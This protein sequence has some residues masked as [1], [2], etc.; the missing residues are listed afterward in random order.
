MKKQF[1]IIS[2]LVLFA[3]AAQAGITTYTFTS[4]QWASKVD[5]TQ[6][7][8][9]TDGWICEQAASEYNAGRTDAQG[10]LNSAGVSV[11]TGT[12][13]AGALSI[14]SFQQV[15]QVTF[16]FCLNSSRG[17]GVIYVQVGNSPWDSLVINRPA[18]SGSGIYNRDS[19]LIIPNN[20]SGKIRF[21]ITCTENA[22]NLNSITIRAQNGGSSVFTTDTYQLVTDVNQLQDSDQVIFGVADGVSNRIMGYFD[23]SVSQNNIHSIVGRYSADRTQVEPND[24]AI[25][26]LRK[27]LLNGET[28]YLFKDEIRYEE[29]YLVA[30]GGQS[31]NR[32]ALWVNPS[33]AKSYGNY[34]YWKIQISP[35]GVATVCSQ[36]TSLGRYIQ[37]NATNTPTL[38]GCYAQPGMQT[39]ICLYRRVAALGDEKAIIAPISSF[40]TVLLNEGIAQA[41]HTV[42]VQ[43]NRL[44]ADIQ[45]SMVSGANFS[46]NKSLL[47]RDGEDLVIHF[48]ATAVGQY[49]DTLVLTGDSIVTRVAVHARVAAPMTIAEASHQAEYTE[50]HLLP[51]QVTKKYDT[52]IY[53][54]D[55]TGCML[56]YDNGNGAGGRYGS[57]VK[58]GD[59]LTDVAG[60]SR[61]YFG[62]PE[63]TPTAA[64]KIGSNTECLPDSNFVQLD[65]A[66]VCRY[67]VLD[68]AMVVS[69]SSLIWKGKTYLY[70][71]TFQYG[72]L[73][74][75]APSRIEAI[76]SYDW[77]KTNLHII[78]QVLKGSTALE[79]TSIKADMPRK[80]IINGRVYILHN[81]MVY[82][83]TGQ[84]F[85]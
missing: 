60:R 14:V 23:E 18:T 1:F 43:A 27:T 77:N 37:Y 82:T 45:A 66:D 2:A 48:S 59:W 40:G 21:R 64:F 62:V 26:T 74:Q 28:A 42:R 7:D 17:K 29:A 5:A 81:G 69:D 36:G 49:T 79:E 15:R 46:L 68:S 9:Q 67:V 32:L 53:I 72:T 55:T 76:V 52:Y 50:I 75:N 83:P 33:D 73:T 41:D 58:K 39:N 31:K 6:T 10:A 22:I 84:R 71:D 78:S 20:P 61:N 13:G 19:T 12:S 4:I 80:Y 44:N 63:L 70:S 51:V 34:G 8:G 65:S 24:E 16:N 85:K 56:I 25:Y 38:F 54:R 57:G 35:E 30:S 47:D 11:K 3:I